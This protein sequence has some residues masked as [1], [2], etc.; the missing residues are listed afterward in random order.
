MKRRWTGSATCLKD[1]AC[2]NTASLPGR[3]RGCIS[4]GA[5]RQN[6]IF[7]RKEFDLPSS[8]FGCTCAAHHPVRTGAGRAL[9]QCRDSLKA[10]NAIRKID[11]ILDILRITLTRNTARKILDVAGRIADALN[12]ARLAAGL[13]ECVA[14]AILLWVASVQ[15]PQYKI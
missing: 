5:G 14:N 4:P 11:G 7:E 6:K 12:V 2:S 13:C 1:P 10:A 3:S 15:R 9:W 8:G